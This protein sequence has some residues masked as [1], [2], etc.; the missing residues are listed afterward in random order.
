[1]PS[2]VVDLPEP[3]PEPQ[4]QPSV[5]IRVRNCHQEKRNPHLDSG[6]SSR[7]SNAYPARL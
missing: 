4:P 3:E 7:P 2:I 1:M 5:S 6:L